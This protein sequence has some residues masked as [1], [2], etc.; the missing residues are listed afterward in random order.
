MI[1][2]AL[3]KGR[4]GDK[5]YNKFAAMGYSCPEITEDSRKLVFEEPSK[6]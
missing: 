5:V 2:I 1:S 3:P 6:A 4:L